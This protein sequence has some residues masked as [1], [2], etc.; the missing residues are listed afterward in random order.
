MDYTFKPDVPFAGISFEDTEAQ[1]IEKLG[2]PDNR[3]VDAEGDNKEVTLEYEELGLN[4]VFNYIDDEQ[5][6]LDIFTD[7]LIVEGK[8]LYELDETDALHLL[9]R[10]GDSNEEEAYITHND[11]QDGEEVMYSFDA[12][13][14][15]IWCIDGQ[16]V[17]VC[18]TVPYV[19]IDDFEEE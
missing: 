19:N 13:G 15:T 7:Q 5:M 8:D 1:V 14:I 10:L 11:T 12:L 18:V 2:Q 3:E 6:P 4:I 16:V 9:T 17:D